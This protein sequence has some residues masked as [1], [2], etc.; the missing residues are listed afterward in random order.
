MKIENNKIVFND[1]TKKYCSHGIIG[2]G[3]NLDVYDGYDG[4]LYSKNLCDGDIEDGFGKES[5]YCMSEEHMVEIADYMIKMWAFF[6]DLHLND[7]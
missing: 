6:R 5:E 7:K 3:C 4:I 1:G 2:L